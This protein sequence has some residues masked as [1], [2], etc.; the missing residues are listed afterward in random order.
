MNCP[1][2]GAPAPDN[3][4]FCQECGGALQIVCPQC[5]QTA[6]P[7]VRFCGNCGT[8]LGA[9]DGA[10]ADTKAGLMGAFPSPP[11][12]PA[13]SPAP[14]APAPNYPAPTQYGMAAPPPPPAAPAP[15]PAWQAPPPP[16]AAPSAW[17][18]APPPPANAPSWQVPAGFEAA[19][20]GYEF[21]GVMPRFF[22]ALIDGAIV[23]LV[24]AVIMAL[25][26]S[27]GGMYDEG[28]LYAVYTIV[29]LLSLAYTLLLEA[30]GGTLGK[31][32]LGMRIVS[33]DDGGAPGFKRSLV[34]NL[35]RIVDGLPVM[36]LVGILSIASSDK[37]QRVGDRV[38][39]TYV[40]KK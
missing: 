39:G 9:Q 33:A 22:A 6:A 38:A 3:A 35:M 36:Y 21:I 20:T 8:R 14:S 30:G 12:P 34:R 15:A 37:K 11:P 26:M 7:G 13:A 24:G 10:K 4:R 16:A 31:R 25:A 2:C 29:M 27:G 19:H 5:G 40:V 1:H 28:T 32:I 17:Q 18:P 23:G